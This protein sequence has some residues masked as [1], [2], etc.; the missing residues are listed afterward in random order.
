MSGK[1]ITGLKNEVVR[2]GR[3]ILES[4]LVVGS[5]GNISARVP[6]DPN[7]IV[8]TPSQVNYE[9]LTPD[10]LVVVDLSGKRIEGKRNPSIEIKMHLAIYRSREDVGAVIHTHPI[11]ASAFAVARK[12]IPPLVDEFLAHVG[13]EVKVAEYA[14]P[15]TEELANNAVAALEDRNAVL[16]ANHGLLCCGKDLEEAFLVTQLVERAAMIYILAS[17][18]GD[19]HLLPEESIKFGTQMYRLLRGTRRR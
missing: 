1:D 3:K 18:I 12:N 19:V 14:M 11:F 17:G 6:E 7:L 16:L 2:Y 15:G 10:D 9:D 13:G 4:G 5:A 8:V